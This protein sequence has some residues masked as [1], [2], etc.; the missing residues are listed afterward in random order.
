MAPVH[1]ITSMSLR[2][3]RPKCSCARAFYKKFESATGVFQQLAVASLPLDRDI[4]RIMKTT[5]RLL[6]TELEVENTNY[7]CLCFT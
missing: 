7:F 5:Q 3:S 2:V 1:T 6:I 4:D